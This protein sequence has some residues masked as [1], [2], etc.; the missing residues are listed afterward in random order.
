[1]RFLYHQLELVMVQEWKHGNRTV[2]THLHI[3]ISSLGGLN[4]AIE[5]NLQKCYLYFLAH[6]YYSR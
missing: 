4:I 2:N 1:L 3:V 6:F 5:S